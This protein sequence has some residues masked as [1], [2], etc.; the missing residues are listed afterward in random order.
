[1]SRIL[2]LDEEFSLEIRLPRNLAQQ[3]WIGWDEAQSD[4]EDAGA[5][6]PECIA[7]EKVIDCALVLIIEKYFFA[8]EQNAMC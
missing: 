5:L 3:I 2:H 1:M 8:R 4:D 6:T 7:R